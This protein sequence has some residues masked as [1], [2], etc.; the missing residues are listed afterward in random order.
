MKTAARLSLFLDFDGTLV[1][2]EANPASPRLDPGTAEALKA[3]SDRDFLVTTI[4]SGRAVED[5]Y[6]RIRVQGLIYAGNHGLEI[7]GRNLR[8]VEP[9]AVAWREQL[10]RLC[11]GLLVELQPI[12]GAIVEFKGLTASIHYRQVAESDPPTV[13]EAV[14]AAVV[15][16]GDLFRLNPA[17][18]VFEIMPRTGWHKGAAVRWIDERLGGDEVLPVY[19]GDDTADEEAFRILPEAVT[20]RVGARRAICARYSLPDPAAVQEFLLWLGILVSERL[21]NG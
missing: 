15:R 8:F 6:A 12:A 14:R 21:R 9:G 5:V 19:L 11:D 3:L 17:R 10:E 18:K 20:V 1:P 16:A 2:I 13:E 7:F 4:I